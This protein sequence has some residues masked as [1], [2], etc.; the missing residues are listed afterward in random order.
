LSSMR[1]LHRHVVVLLA[2]LLTPASS[3]SFSKTLLRG[4]TLIVEVTQ[5]NL[6]LAW[7]LDVQD[8]SADLRE[9]GAT[10]LLVSHALFGTVV[11]EQA[12]A[13]GNFPGPLPVLC[14][15]DASDPA[16]GSLLTEVSGGGAAGIAVR[17]EEGTASGASLGEV[18]AA[19]A[20]EGLALL[21]LAADDASQTAAATAGATAVVCVSPDTEAAP[22][23]ATSGSAEKT[24]VVVGAWDGDE[25]G[26]QQLRDAGFNAAL[27]LDGCGGD[28]ASGRAWCES[29]VRVF[30]SKASKS[31]G[32]S[33]FGS[34]SSDVAPPG[35]R[36]PRMWAQ[37]QRQARE[38]MHES[39]KSR[40]LPAPKI[41]RNSVLGGKG[42]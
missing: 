17:C 38:I 22:L 14:Q 7:T 2:L 16:F 1:D 20:A 36:N 40:G 18:V 42:A 5:D 41:K 10:A 26:L 33:M 32:G 24:C 27:L 9:A 12:T 37:S 8:L 28:I 39:A 34:T 6:D 15:L 29:R 25:E 21:A 3:S 11:D 35:A 4:R 30:R 13:R 31:W 23:S 19:T